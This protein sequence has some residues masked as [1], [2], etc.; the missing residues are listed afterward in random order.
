MKIS[1]EILRDYANQERTMNNE[2]YSNQTQS[3]PIP[4]PAIHLFCQKSTPPDR[5]L[6][7]S[8]G[9]SYRR[10]SHPGRSALCTAGTA[11]SL[12]PPPRI[13]LLIFHSFDLSTS[14]ISQMCL[15]PSCSQI[16]THFTIHPSRRKAKSSLKWFVA[17][18]ISPIFRR[19]NLD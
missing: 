11:W 12:P 14:P 8:C 7:R 1:T 18:H 4:P 13:N 5:F 15:K 3:N 17:V 10:I 9:R 6:R 16:N 19:K 2:R